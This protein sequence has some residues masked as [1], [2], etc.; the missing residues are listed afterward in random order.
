MVNIINTSILAVLYYNL[1]KENSYDLEN[2]KDRKKAQSNFEN[3]KKIDTELL[4]QAYE[5]YKQMM[6]KEFENF[7]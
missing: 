1:K 2:G 3:T 4:A 6:E 5:R 7:L